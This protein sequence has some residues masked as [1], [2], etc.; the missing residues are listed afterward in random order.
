MKPDFALDFRDN[1]IALLHRQDAGWAIIGR[2]AMDDPDL[3]AAMAYLRATA[4]GLSPRGV[5]AKLILPNEAILY[6]ELENLPYGQDRRAAAIERALVGRTP[7]GVD[8]LVYDWTDAGASAHVAVIAR[9]TLEEAEGF[10]SQ[11]RFNPVSFAA[12]PDQGGYDGEVWFGSTQLSETLLARGEV[13]ERD[14]VTLLALDTGAAPPAELAASDFEM[15]AAQDA[16]P[17]GDDPAEAEPDPA[18]VDAPAAQTDPAPPQVQDTREVLQDFVMEEPA[19][20]ADASDVA[21]DEPT[22]VLLLEP[23]VAPAEKEPPAPLRLADQ[24]DRQHPPASF[25]AAFD[26]TPE[27]SAPDTLDEVEEAPMAVDVPLIDDIPAPDSFGEKSPSRAEKMLAAFAA[28]R[29][30]ALAKAEAETNAR[31]VEPALRADKADAAQASLPLDLAMADMA[32]DVPAPS[33][34]ISAKVQPKMAELGLASGDRSAQPS[35]PASLPELGVPDAKIG[36]APEMA[37][38]TGLR[39]AIVKHV[40]AKP[41]P[42]KPQDLKAMP[43]PKARARLGMGMGWILTAVLL[44]ALV[45][46]GA[47]SELMLTSY[48]ALYG[49]DSAL[50]SIE[51]SQTPQTA[52]QDNTA[53]IATAAAL[54]APKAPMADLSAAQVAPQVVAEIASMSAAGVSP[55]PVVPA[56]TPLAQTMPPAGAPDLALPPLDMVASAPDLPKTPITDDIAGQASAVDVASALPVP[57][58]RP[59]EITR[60]DIA[61]P[62]VFVVTGKPALVPGPRPD[63]VLAAAALARPAAAAPAPELAAL[64]AADPSLAGA[65]PLPRPASVLAAAAAAAPAL[66]PPPAADPALADARPSKRPDNIL[67][68]GRAARLASAS[69]SIVAGAQD[70]I[71]EAAL[72]PAPLTPDP[73]L[74]PLAVTVSRIPAPRPDGLKSAFE[75]ALAAAAALEPA[76]EASAPAQEVA[77]NEAPVDASVEEDVGLDGGAAERSV[78]AK[79][80]TQRNMLNLRDTN[81]VGIFGSQANRYALIRQPG[82]SFKKL[83]VGDRFDGGRIA[84]ITESEVRYEKGGDLVALSMPKI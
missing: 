22:P 69:A 77:S 10:A 31:R 40:P 5:S 14:D 2:V 37:A 16:E 8:D 3:D 44:V 4:L 24:E 13:V 9:E 19:A 63:I 62:A 49:K 35:A 27:P 17:M 7:Y 46:A 84:A 81:L 20:Q 43:K 75:Q 76:P 39:P 79:Q 68:A 65:K 54:A 15:G 38:A 1:Q 26:E 80:A 59:P 50:A 52:P 42:H 56:A 23:Q 45:A 57:A 28:R 53:Q 55:P 51:P 64:P 61:T 34:P 70:A 32:A 58:P 33:A 47:L 66:G 36:R 48:N 25:A 6:T 71:A 74:S 82:G 41:Q 21:L 72:N 29:D 18:P 11:H 67:A 60:T 78:V 83:K 12:L 30:A 73:N